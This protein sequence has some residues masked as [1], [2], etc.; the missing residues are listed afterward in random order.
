[1]ETNINA[2]KEFW[3]AKSKQYKTPFLWAVLFGLL[4]HG[5]CLFNIINIHDTVYVTPSGTGSSIQNGRWLL[6]ILSNFVE[7]IW[8]HYQI[9]LFHGIAAILMLAFCGCLICEIL[10]IRSKAFATFIV[11]L[12][13][14]FPSAGDTMIYAT[15]AVYFALAELLAVLGVWFAKN[16][17][18]GFLLSVLCYAASLGT[19]QT[20]FPMAATLL[21]LLLL[22]SCFPRTK[23]ETPRFRDVFFRSL[24]SLFSLALGFFLFYGALQFFLD[25]YNLELT[26]YQHSNEMGV[27]LSRL[28]AVLFRAWREVAQLSSVRVYGVNLTGI[29][30]LSIL[31]CQL[32]SLAALL[33]L[34]FCVKVDKGTKF[35]SVV[36]FLLLPLSING[37]VIMCWQSAITVR[38]AYGLVFVYF[39]PIVL[40]EMIDR[41]PPELKKARPGSVQA[42]GGIPAK[43]LAAGLLNISL[44]L[45]ALN[46]CWQ[47]NGNDQLLYYTNQQTVHYFQTMLTQMRIQEGYRPDTKLVIVGETI[48]DPAF[49]NPMVTWDRKEIYKLFPGKQI[50]DYTRYS[51]W[52]NY[53]G[54]NQPLAS[55]AENEKVALLPEVR[56]MPCYPAEG[57]VRIVD[58]YLVLK[59]E[60]TVP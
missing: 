6:F 58:G 10:E 7:R 11:A 41:I 51:W 39:E 48:T 30:R 16:V 50:N 24:K 27:P 45:A 33:Y 4:A 21:V 8:G 17:R 9:P 26:G 36:L 46:Y 22:Q 35:A 14:V 59:L 60:D 34:L 56:Q 25:F 5:F 49:D 2:C 40:L 29:V 19:Y 28:P 38:M 52:I 3:Q 54:F 18:G 57:S 13:V 15:G 42:G 23:E 53:F 12:C 55:A 47:I 32:I 44:F 43:L 1:M 37:I 20:Y 31:I